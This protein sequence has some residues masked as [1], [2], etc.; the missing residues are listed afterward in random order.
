ML[1]ELFAK[2]PN[3][4]I[5]TDIDGFLCG[6]ILQHYFQCNIVGFS[7][8]KKEIWITPDVKSIYDPV[9]IDLYVARP[10]VVCMERI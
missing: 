6:A 4:I 5:N 8:S 2:N 9:Y 1:K 7:N 3:I 10:D